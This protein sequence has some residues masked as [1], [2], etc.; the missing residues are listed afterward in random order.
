MQGEFALE[1]KVDET[2]TS[3]LLGLSLVFF[4]AVFSIVGALILTFYIPRLVGYYN[5]LAGAPSPI[6]QVVLL[7]LGP[8][9]SRLVVFTSSVIGMMIG[10]FLS[11]FVTTKLDVVRKE[12]KVEL[13]ARMH[14]G[15]YFWWVVLFMPLQMIFLLQ[16]IVYGIPTSHFL[17]DIGFSLM[18][19][20]SL[21]FA[22]PILLKYIILVRHVKPIDSR[23]ELIAVRSGSGFKRR[24]KYSVLRVIPYGPDP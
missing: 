6:D 18:A 13:S 7:L 24:L 19:G 15:L 5:Y 23:V 12:G 20:F 11:H 2:D 21:A 1:Q 8:D 4:P 22:V 14:I 16:W 9:L 17:D 10:L 3:Y